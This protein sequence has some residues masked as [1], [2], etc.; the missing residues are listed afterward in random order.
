MTQLDFAVVG[1]FVQT[2]RNCRQLRMCRPRLHTA[3][4]TQLALASA[5]CI[6]HLH[7]S[8]SV[9]VLHSNTTHLIIDCRQSYDNSEQSMFL[10]QCI[11]CAA[12]C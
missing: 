10:D 1:I 3:D 8:V 9:S 4:A 6:G 5:V 7:V 12:T 11:A 2:R